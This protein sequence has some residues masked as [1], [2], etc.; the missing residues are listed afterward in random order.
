MVYGRDSPTLRS[1]E[2]GDAS[3]PVVDTMMTDRDSFLAD[4]CERL[5]QAHKY[6][7]H[8]YNANHRDISF[9]VGEWVWLHLSQRQALS[10]SAH[11]RVKL[12][13]RYFGPYQVS[14]RIGE[15]AYRLLPTGAYS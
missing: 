8:Y 14:D 13:P 12:S 15:V 4:V 2:R 5:L 1:Y 3:V 7:K 9:Q 10:L 11:A 6:A